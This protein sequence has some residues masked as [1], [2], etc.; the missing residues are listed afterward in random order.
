MSEIVTEFGAVAAALAAASDMTPASIIRLAGSRRARVI[1]G[2][3]AS[4]TFQVAGAPVGTS[5]F[6]ARLVIGQ[7]DIKPGTSLLYGVNGALTATDALIKRV[8]VDTPVEVG[9]S[10]Q[11]LWPDGGQH[12]MFVPAAVPLFAVL[13]A[14]QSSFGEDPVKAGNFRLSLYG[15]EI[16]SPDSIAGMRLR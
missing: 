16:E 14:L 12:A 9:R 8:M 13:G 1:T 6:F 2:A 4:A 11:Q 7:G 15:Y 3:I 10:F 5:P